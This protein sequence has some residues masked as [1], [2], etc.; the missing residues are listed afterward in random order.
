M[1]SRCSP[2]RAAWPPT[3][4]GSASAPPGDPR[5]RSG[6]RVPHRGGADRAPAGAGAPVRPVRLAGRCGRRAAANRARRRDRRADRQPGRIN[7]RQPGI[8]VLSVGAVRRQ[9]RSDHDRRGRPDH[10][11]SAGGGIAGWPGWRWCC[12]RSTPAARSDQVVFGWTFLPF[13]NPQQAAAGCVVAPP[14]ARGDRLTRG[15]VRRIRR[16]R[17]SS[18]RPDW[19]RAGLS[20]PQGKVGSGDVSGPA[21][22]CLS[23]E[24]Q[25]PMA[26]AAER[27]AHRGPGARARPS[28][29]GGRRTPGQMSDIDLA[30]I[31]RR[32]AAA[33][34]RPG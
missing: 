2:R 22:G 18:G 26:N 24:T 17:R 6:S 10:A 34:N 30:D 25:P 15:P 33:T 32:A 4:T 20:V 27:T 29:C 7:A 28:V 21:V 16:W 5:R 9:R 19:R 31:A 14:G 11:A 13:A 8:L 1:R 3:A 23:R 12:R